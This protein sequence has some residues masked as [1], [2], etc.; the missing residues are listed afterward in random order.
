MREGAPARGPDVEPLIQV[1]GL[2]LLGNGGEARE[3][4]RGHD[5]PESGKKRRQDKDGSNQPAGTALREKNGGAG[6]SNDRGQ[7]AFPG[8]REQ[9]SHQ[10]KREEIG[11]ASCRERVS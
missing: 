9:N 7:E 8:S 2:E 1:A 3:S 4:R 11:R 10:A 6:N 5:E